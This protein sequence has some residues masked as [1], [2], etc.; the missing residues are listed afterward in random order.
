MFGCGDDIP[1]WAVDD[2]DPILR[3]GTHVYVVD[4]YAGSCNDFELSSCC[5]DRSR[6]F[7]FGADYEGLVGGDL[8]EEVLGGE[9]LGLVDFEVGG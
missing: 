9:V 2:D 3:C 5:E 4:S 6:D 8:G 7:C 1:T